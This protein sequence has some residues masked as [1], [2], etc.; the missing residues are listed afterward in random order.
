M[1]NATLAEIVAVLE[2]VLTA[3]LTA[4]MPGATVPDGVSNDGVSRRTL[5]ARA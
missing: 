1:E 4:H 2:P 5:C 3:T